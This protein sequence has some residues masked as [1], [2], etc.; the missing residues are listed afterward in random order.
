MKH[1]NTNLETKNFF[2][3]TKSPII[4]KTLDFCKKASLT[5]SNILLS[6]ES[7]TGKEV[8]SR[9]IHNLGKRKDENFVAVN[10]SSFSDTLLESELFGHEKGAFTNAYDSKKGKIELAD[11]GTLFLDEIGDTSTSTQI[12]LLRTL[13]TKEVERIG[14]NSLK[15]IDFR[16]ISAT[17]VDLKDAIIKETFRE[18]FFYRVSTIV[19]TVPPLRERMED[20]PDFISYF[21][22]KYSAETGIEI[23][24]IE[25]DVFDFLYE[26]DYP[27]N[28]RELKNIIERM[29]VFSENGIIT[30]DGL[31][32]MHSYYSPNCAANCKILEKRD[33]FSEIISFDQ[34]KRN[35]EKEYLTWVLSQV[36]GNVAE[37]AR[38][39][40]ISS[41]Q[42]F[43][44]I[45]TLGIKK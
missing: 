30:R 35:S 41:R 1:I 29:V 7:G 23:H 34:F 36:G 3:E 28:I 21:L 12:K 10:C 8:L 5:N 42:I 27:G 6:G 44:K 37:A 18:D 20:L 22:A 16:L 9:H 45:N 40:E 15:K 32:V 19:I 13:E 17:N 2:L 39:L 26:Y 31:P 4:R 14:S 43:N 11:K 24:S 33:K 38:R 25:D